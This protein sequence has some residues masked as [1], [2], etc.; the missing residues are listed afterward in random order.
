MK[1]KKAIILA[2][3]IVPHKKVF[4]YLMKKQ[5][6]NYII[7]ADGGIENAI[8]LKIPVDIII[9]D[10]DSAKSDLKNKLLKNAKVVY[11]KRQSDTDMEKA[12]KYAKSKG[13]SDIV[14]LGADGLRMDHTLSNIGL[15][16]KYKEQLNLRIVTN[17][18]VIFPCSRK[19][20]FE[21]VKGETIS[22]YNFSESGNITTNGLKYP[23]KKTNLKFGVSESIS[24]VST[25]DKV[26][27]ESSSDKTIIIRS[28]EFM[29]KYNLL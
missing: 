22:I 12:I 16:I 7:C 23:L 5:G 17:T 4:N 27:I 19:L 21:S 1:S 26:I 9:G 6:Y 15:I 2:G 8:K 13:Y 24:N 20:H 10:L 25:S 29:I 18:S 3:A 28:T 11:L 14:L